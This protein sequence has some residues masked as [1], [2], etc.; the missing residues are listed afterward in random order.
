MNAKEKT[1]QHFDTIA[2]D[3]NQSSDGKF[4]QPMYQPILSELKTPHGGKLLDI[5]CGNGNL[6][7]FLNKGL[8]DL[9]GIDFSQKMIA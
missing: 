2:S 8:F 9:Y 1:K 5:G 4:V 6:F 3:Y 7:G